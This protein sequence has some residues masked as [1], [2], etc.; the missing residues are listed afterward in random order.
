MFQQSSTLT[1]YFPLIFLVLPSLL[2]LFLP[3]GCFL[4]ESGTEV[5]YASP[6]L[7]YKQQD[8]VLITDK[9]YA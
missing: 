8:Q 2:D 1:V 3:C 5:H 9:S 6:I 7:T 4:R